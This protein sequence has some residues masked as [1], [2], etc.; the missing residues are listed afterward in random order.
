[1][2]TYFLQHECISFQN[3]S[4]SKDVVWYSPAIFIKK[5][6]SIDFFTKSS[7]AKISKKSKK[8]SVLAEAKNSSVVFENKKKL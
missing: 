4:Q 3:Q 8:F 7:I 2:L 1:M 5:K 6:K